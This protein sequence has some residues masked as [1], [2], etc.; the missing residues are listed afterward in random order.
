MNTQSIHLDIPTETLSSFLSWCD[1][2]GYEPN[3]IITALMQ[4][5]FALDRTTQTLLISDL[6]ELDRAQVALIALNRIA[7]TDT[8]NQPSLPKSPS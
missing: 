7:K 4:W 5:F 3:G 6:H 2:A 8:P 1:Q